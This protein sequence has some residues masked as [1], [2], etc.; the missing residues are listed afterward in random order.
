MA[1]AR[2]RVFDE[3]KVKR[4]KGGEFSTVAEQR[5]QAANERAS[6]AARGHLAALDAIKAR[7]EKR[8]TRAPMK[9]AEKEDARRRREQDEAARDEAKLKE[10]GRLD[11]SATIVREELSGSD[12]ESR[13]KRV[14]AEIALSKIQE[15]A[16][17][18][19]TRLK[20]TMSEADAFELAKRAGLDPG[21]AATVHA[22]L[23]NA[24]GA[25]GAVAGAVNR[26][27]SERAAR[28]KE[29]AAAQKRRETEDRK[30]AA[31]A[32]RAVRAANKR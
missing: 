20:R 23:L 11:G 15:Q 29:A 32:K 13:A 8:A 21:N 26:A 9:D 22:V 5:I 12:P 16:R 2:S 6:E 31:A 7:Q 14:A 28:E 10:I 30:A 24:A 18:E 25:G 3:A 17:L 4:N 27:D 19:G 1:E